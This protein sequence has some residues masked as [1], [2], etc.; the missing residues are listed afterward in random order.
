MLLRSYPPL[1][2]H[3]A[4]HPPHPRPMSLHEI[5]FRQ[6]SVSMLKAELK[7]V[8]SDRDVIRDD[9][10]L[11]RDELSSKN[12]QSKIEPRK[13]IMATDLRR[14]AEATGKGIN[15]IGAG[16]GVSAPA[17]RTGFFTGSDIVLGPIE[18]H[19]DYDRLQSKCDLVGKELQS[20]RQ[21]HVETVNKCDKALKEADMYR[22]KYKLTKDKMEQ[23]IN[24]MTAIRAQCKA[25]L[26]DKQRYEQ[27]VI[28]LQR[29]HKQDQLEIEELQKQQRE[30]L[31][32]SGSSEVYT[33]YDATLDKYKYM[34]QE[35]ENLRQR[36]NDL[37]VQHNANLSKLE[38]SQEET[39]RLRTRYEEVVADLNSGILE[40]KGLQQQCTAA[41][42][43][44]HNALHET[45]EAEKDL[46]K[47]KMERD[48][49]KK[50]Q[51]QAISETIKTSKDIG[52]LR[53]ER[54]AV[55]HEYTLVMSERDAVHRE[56]EQLQDKLTDLEKR[57]SQSETEKKTAR[58]EL[59]TLREEL[60]SVVHDRDNTH[61]LL[62]DLQQKVG[63]EKAT[64]KL[65]GSERELALLDSRESDSLRMANSYDAIKKE[66]AESREQLNKETEALR[67]KIEQIQ[68]E[69]NGE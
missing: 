15:P 60:T 34:K 43:K 6:N 66:G 8:A 14:S 69:L 37:S 46:Q 39:K 54:N 30:A 20:L 68:T 12:M 52:R 13:H 10:D 29:V 53:S 17:E 61:K 44:W 33:M 64:Q 9:R 26:A 63:M 21:Q 5:D 48:E 57:Y 35:N 51:K 65:E 3:P 56:M 19:R 31:S 27:E 36:Y 16:A 24:E 28:D 42:M 45:R 50:G 47:S 67:V 7:L 1:H 58:V 59:E 62:A 22:S 11:L 55:V 40:R 41:I 18:K 2:P 25:I 49:Y 32:E 38:M 23:T 4:A